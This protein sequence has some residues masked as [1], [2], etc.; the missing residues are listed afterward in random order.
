MDVSNSYAEFSE[1][2]EDAPKLR[3]SE[4]LPIMD[5]SLQNAYQVVM[6][7]W[8]RVH[9]IEAEHRYAAR[10]MLLLSIIT[11]VLVIATGVG[12]YFAILLF[13]PTRD[14]TPVII[15]SATLAVICVGTPTFILGDIY[16]RYRLFRRY[17]HLLKTQ[18]AEIAPITRTGF[19]NML[20]A[21]QARARYWSWLQHTVADY[22]LHRKR[23]DSPTYDESYAT[24]QQ[25]CINTRLPF[26]NS[27]LMSALR[28]SNSSIVI[29]DTNPMPQPFAKDSDYY[30]KVILLGVLSRSRPSIV[31]DTILTIS[32]QSDAMDSGV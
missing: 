19:I 32:T 25:I 6:N 10:C 8:K 9:L 22:R 13:W 28:R 5:Q 31:G 21:D 26:Y 16:R 30:T 4:P 14:Y 1:S 18:F 23:I 24:I 12:I 29:L 3:A 11:L 15:I 27:D 7:Y 17:K 2:A 20:V